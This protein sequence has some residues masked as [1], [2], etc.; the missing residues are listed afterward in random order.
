[1]A[2]PPR[3]GEDKH[4]NAIFLIYYLQFHYDRR[5]YVLRRDPKPDELLGDSAVRETFPFDTAPE[6]LI[7]DRGSRFNDEMV[8]VV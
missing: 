8:E 2:F 5:G 7:F 4:H 3:D 6:Y 1:M